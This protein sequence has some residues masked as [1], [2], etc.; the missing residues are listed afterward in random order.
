[1]SIIRNFARLGRFMFGERWFRLDDPHCTSKK[2]RA[3]RFEQLEIRNPLTASPLPVHLGSVY[4]EQA[5]GD[6]SAPNVIKVTFAG[7][8]PGTQLKQLVIDGD[9]D[10]NGTYSSGEVFFDTAAG[11]MGVFKS[12]PFQVDAGKHHRR[13]SSHQLFRGRRRPEA[14]HQL[15]QLRRRRRVRLHHRRRRSAIRRSANRRRRCQRR[16]RRQRVPTLDHDGHVH[17]P[18][19]LRCHRQHQVLGRVRYEFRR[20]QCQSPA[21]R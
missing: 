8:A 6:D 15:Q 12:N 19:L 18:A 10:G 21:P 17:R 7:G 2:V 9:K 20:R 16:R 13:H 14:D 11:G 4:L 3:C 5:S 1:M